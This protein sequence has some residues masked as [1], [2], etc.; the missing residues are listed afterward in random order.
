MP[1]TILL[2]DDSMTAQK[3]GKEILV[4]AGYNVIAVSNGAAAAK[5]LVEKPDI[6]ILD[7]FMPG[8]TGLEICEK[9]RASMETAKTP[10]LLTVGKMEHFDPQESARVKADG[11]IIKP[12]EAT[13][14]LATIKK[15][16]QK[17]AAN[18]A[19]ETPSYEKTMIL[20]RAQIQEFKD[21]SYDEWKTD[22]TEM[23]VLPPP[24]MEMSSEMG[25]A[26]AFGDDMMGTPASAT[27]MDETVTFP[28]PIPA[29]KAASA[30]FDETVNFPPAI[31]SF[32]DM[33]PASMDET[34]N[35][36]PPMAASSMSMD[37]TVNFPPP[38]A[39]APVM[40]FAPMEMTSA[41]VTMD[42]LPSMPAT[43]SEV[44]FTSAPRGNDAQVVIEEGLEAD[45]VEIA[46]TQQDPALVTD[47]TTMATE[48]VTKFGV[49]KEEEDTYVPGFEKPELPTESEA[50]AAASDDDFEARVAAAMN[51]FETEAP[52]AVAISGVE[53][54]AAIEPIEV[55][56]IEVAEIPE[57]IMPEP[58]M[59]APEPIAPSFPS[60]T[61]TQEMAAVVDAMEPEPNIEPSQLPPEG[62]QDAALVEQMQQ[63][64]ADLPVA[65]P[66]PVEEPIVE[67]A[68]AAAAPAPMAT[69]AGPDLELANA[70]AAAVGGEPPAAVA[71]VAS[72][73]AASG[74]GLDPHTIAAV[75]SRVM[76]RMLPSIMTEV[77]K[78][79]DN[80]KK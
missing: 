54:P 2:A 12:F 52:A 62:M 65:P 42:P 75:V 8:Y 69:N 64:F 76:E 43:E 51:S 16:E 59:M 55:E 4:S 44:E 50:P 17:I 45:N 20:D 78:E 22:A 60:S 5:K 70:L 9:V 56:P 21:A 11:L 18:V 53:A 26:P 66:A 68:V 79:L 67:A 1:L 23:E 38:V 27:A 30:S 37:E 33:N 7:V 6:I 46:V 58:V 74:P 61:D 13:D 24:P 15:L 36:P 63:A 40:D 49:E 39:A 47:P 10:V 34:V 71:A 80:A 28:P 32:A 72:A 41:P 77:A 48:F 14:L 31:P 73:A 3:M 35:F 57:P 29:A 25:S 19:A